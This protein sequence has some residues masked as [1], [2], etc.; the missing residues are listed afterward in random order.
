MRAFVFAVLAAAALVAAVRAGWLEP[1]K[2]EGCTERLRFDGVAYEAR[3]VAEE[4][5]GVAALGEATLSICD[6]RE[7]RARS[8]DVYRVAGA[9]PA[10]VV[11][12]SGHDDYTL[13]VR[14]GS[15]SDELPADLA[16]LIEGSGD[17]GGV[18][19]P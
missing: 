2:E 6:G 11:V 7:Q 14:A 3:R 9:P 4:V 13:Y 1:D 8:V 10:T 19:R 17:T 16:E 5:P 18:G 12:A 15:T